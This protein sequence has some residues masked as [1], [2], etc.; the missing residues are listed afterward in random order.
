M[1]LKKRQC[2]NR[3]SWIKSPDHKIEISGEANPGKIREQKPPGK[4]FDPVKFNHRYS[5]EH[6]KNQKPEERRKIF[7]EV[8]ENKRPAKIKNKLSTV[9][10]Q[11]GINL[12]SV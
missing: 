6:K 11:C 8:K 2:S 7:P 9:K 3:I 4:F 10:K 1:N 12:P 5:D